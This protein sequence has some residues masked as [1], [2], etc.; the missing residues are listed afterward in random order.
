MYTLNKFLQIKKS[1][2]LDSFYIIYVQYPFYIKCDSKFYVSREMKKILYYLKKI[3]NFE[4]TIFYEIL[5]N[6][7]DEIKKMIRMLISNK[8]ILN[9]LK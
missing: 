8:V 4:L 7:E 1:Y 2:A 9:E 5:N 6:S 3:K